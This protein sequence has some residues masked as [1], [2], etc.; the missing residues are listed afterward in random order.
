V[1]VSDKTGQTR[2]RLQLAYAHTSVNINVNG[3]GHPL[4]TRLHLI[5]LDSN[6]LMNI[7]YLISPSQ[8]KK[9]W[10]AGFNPIADK[11]C[12]LSSKLEITIAID[13]LLDSG[14][15]ADIFNP[16]IDI[17][18]CRRLVQSITSNSG[19]KAQESLG[20][21]CN[22]LNIHVLTER[23][24]MRNDSPVGF[25][26]DMPI[27]KRQSLSLNLTIGSQELTGGLLTMLRIGGQQVEDALLLTLDLKATPNLTKVDLND[28]VRLSIDIGKGMEGVFGGKVTEARYS[29]EDRFAISCRSHGLT[30]EDTMIPGLVMRVSGGAEQ[31]YYILRSSG[32]QS[33]KLLIDGLNETEKTR[34]CLI[35]TPIANIKAD[36]PFGIGDVTFAKLEKEDKDAL[37]SLTPEVNENFPRLH[38]DKIWARTY[39][40]APHFYEAQVAGI[41]KI[42]MALDL[43][44][45]V[46]SDS[47][48][49]HFSDVE[50]VPVSWKRSDRFSN[51]TREPWVYIQDLATRECILASTEYV[52]NTRKLGM[53]PSLLSRL[54][55]GTNKLQILFQQSWDELNAREKS[56]VY[57]LHWLRRA[58]EEGTNVD[59]LMYLWNA[60]EFISAPTKN[61][62]LFRKE[63]IKTIRKLTH[64]SIAKDDPKKALKAERLDEL[65]AMLNKPS[66]LTQLKWLTESEDI[67]LSDEEWEYVRKARDK[68]NDVIHGHGNVV[69]DDAE[70]IK[71][72]FIVSKIISGLSLKV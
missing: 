22:V 52:I 5:H 10:L 8:N 24:A 16:N 38:E 70:A 27:I 47:K 65:V 37:N 18:L 59:K 39:V 51:V 44:S 54:E 46:R 35:L 33:E 58:R 53:T 57:A 31:M 30:L 61:Q 60:I 63:E 1:K 19:D 55:K 3:K 40:P 34:F 29:D 72:C 36:K 62:R 12:P 68:R 11:I 48:P 69:F 71:L 2:D 9:G 13:R 14:G 15:F 43:L 32:W 66:L 23:R 45:D 42:N 67:A 28:D 56:L 50:H 26:D 7:L 21:L 64:D 49:F 4:E 20:K 25:G 17:A 6:I 41:D